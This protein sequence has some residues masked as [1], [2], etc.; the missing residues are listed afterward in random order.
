MRSPLATLA[1]SAAL[2]SPATAQL[3]ADAGV[4]LPD[5]RVVTK[6]FVTLGDASQP[7]YPVARFPLV[8]YSFSDSL[9]LATDDAGI[10]VTGLAPGDYRV[11]SPAPIDFH[12]RSYRWSVP[13]TVR[14]GVSTVNL[15]AANAAVTVPVVPTAVSR[16]DATVRAAPAPTTARVIGA[17]IDNGLVPDTSAAAAGRITSAPY[18]VARDGYSWDYVYRAYV[19]GVD[20]DSTRVV[21]TVTRRRVGRTGRRWLPSMPQ[22][23]RRGP[24]VREDDEP[25]TSASGGAE[26]PLWARLQ[27]VATALRSP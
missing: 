12:G 26:K 23:L 24:E 1:L 7:Y 18:R 10:V 19:L 14:E 9:A 16:L 11:V 2:A 8:A 3:R 17:F 27:R 4:V 22:V 25:L 13:V 5:G 20:R 21:L 15:T 6:I